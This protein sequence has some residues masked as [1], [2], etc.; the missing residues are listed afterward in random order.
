MRLVDG[1]DPVELGIERGRTAVASDISVLPNE[2][3]LIEEPDVQS[4][5]DRAEEL[6]E[7][8][9]TGGGSG[10]RSRVEEFLL[11]GTDISNKFVILT[12]PVSDPN[13]VSVNVTGGGKQSIVEDYV[14]V[15]QKVNWSGL[16]MD[17]VITAGEELII[18]Y[19]FNG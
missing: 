15:G 4:F 8:L 1:D 12:E 9:Q 11:S 10:T 18:E 6:L 7:A 17:G 3:D 2:I 16:G 5:L 19:E 13:N 14:V